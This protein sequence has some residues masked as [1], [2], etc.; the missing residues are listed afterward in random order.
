MN[1]FSR[2]QNRDARTYPHVDP[3]PVGVNVMATHR[4]ALNDGIDWVP[5]DATTVAHIGAHLPNTVTPV[6][7]A[8]LRAVR[9]A[10]V[11]IQEAA[12]ITDTTGKVPPPDAIEL[13]EALKL[14]AE[15]LRNG[16]VIA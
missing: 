9:A 14:G 4:E 1:P 13:V 12:Y 7:S 5:P 6:P 11:L 3:V 15:A 16:V 10:R 8:N 2:R